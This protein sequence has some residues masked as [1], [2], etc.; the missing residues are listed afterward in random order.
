MYRLKT[1]S[2]F[3]RNKTEKCLNCDRCRIRPCVLDFTLS[4]PQPRNYGGSMVYWPAWQLN[5]SLYWTS[6]G[7]PWRV[8]AGRRREREGE[9]VQRGESGKPLQTRRT[10]HRL[11]LNQTKLRAGKWIII[12]DIRDTSLRE[13][14]IYHQSLYSDFLQINRPNWGKW[15]G[16]ECT[17]SSVLWENHR[18]SQW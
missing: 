3:S 4:S 10:I 1:R 12:E 18:I 16:G 7:N 5:C 17:F 6:L 2:Q 9:R 11:Q 15:T 13:A 8:V 14:N